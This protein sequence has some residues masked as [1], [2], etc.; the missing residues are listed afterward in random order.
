MPIYCME[1]NLP[2]YQLEVDGDELTVNKT[3]FVANPAFMRSFMAFAQTQKFVT[4]DEKRIV[5][6][7]MLVPDL[8]IYRR[9]SSGEYYVQI[10]RENIQKA[11]FAYLK[12]G[13]A[14]AVN[15]EH[16]TDVEGVYMVESFVT[17]S[18]R[19]I[20]APEAL[21]SEPNGTWFASFK[22]DNDKVWQDVKSGKFTGFSIEG[23]FELRKTVDSPENQLQKI[24]E[25]LNS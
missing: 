21:S 25:I 23:E 12:K 13:F 3:S 4:N 16:N 6:G 24:I 9:D 19:G 14:S 2:V 5:T 22:V 11:A 8:P 1:N 18:E 20:L 15:I 10:S 7:A 17:D